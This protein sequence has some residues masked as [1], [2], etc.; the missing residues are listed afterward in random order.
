MTFLSSYTHQA[1]I[2]LSC[3]G[4]KYLICIWLTLAS[5][6]AG[7]AG[8]VGMQGMVWG[9]WHGDWCIWCTEDAIRNIV[10]CAGKRDGK[11][12]KEEIKRMRATNFVEENMEI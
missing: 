12:I 9:W 5:L 4:F 8:E 1:I 2:A 10:C 3:F 11:W 7:E 6:H